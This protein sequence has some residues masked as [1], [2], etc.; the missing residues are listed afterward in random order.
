M[1][2][3]VIILATLLPVE[4]HYD[5][6]ALV[7]SLTE[8][9]AIAPTAE[10][11]FQRAVE[12]R[13]LRET[14]H[15]EE[16]LRKALS[17][18]SDHELSLAAL[19]TLL[20]K[21][22]NHEEAVLTAGNLIKLNPSAP[23]HLLA[24]DVLLAAG[25]VDGAL[26]NVLKGPPNEDHTHLLHSYLLVRKERVK[27][28][29]AVLKQAHVRTKSIVLRNAWLDASIQAGQLDEVIPILEEEIR[30]SRYPAAHRIRRSWAIRSLS[31]E[32][33]DVAQGQLD[34]ALAEINKRLNPDRPDL[35]LVYDRGMALLLMGR[36]EEALKDLELLKQSGISPLSYFW[37]ERQLSQ[38]D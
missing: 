14:D 29:A 15:A 16:D 4:G 22:G 30:T 33:E 37:L 20:S 27:E 2:W 1:K 17:L 5:V 32:F 31:V 10:L 13:A 23:N 6:S 26:G 25:D 12:F 7:K 11:Y 3:L 28:A 24:A 19:A 38:T 36:R 35:T 18:Q 34:A 8:K 9:I 21:T